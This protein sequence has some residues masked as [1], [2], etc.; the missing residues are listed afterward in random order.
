MYD[1]ILVPV[2]GSETGRRALEQAARLATLC[3]AKI[4]LL[5]VLDT[6]LY[7]NGFERPEVYV[8]QVHPSMLRT[9]H[10]IL[11]EARHFL[12][13]RGVPCDCH[14]EE[15]DDRRV[16]EIIVDHARQWGA[17]VIVM[18]THGRRGANRL[19]MG[20]DAEL[21]ART[22]AVPVLLVRLLESEQAA[23]AG[24]SA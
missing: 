3:K 22:A 17:D 21:V 20:S 7:S 14:L 8:H 1:K 4:R 13:Q 9:G 6:L 23:P 10:R 18:G 12:E 24:A 16:S 19:L 2:D 11:T 5:H 15:C